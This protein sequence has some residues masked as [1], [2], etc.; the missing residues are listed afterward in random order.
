MRKGPAFAAFDVG[1]LKWAPMRP[2]PHLYIHIPKTA[3]TSLS[4]AV[5][6]HWGEENF[7][8]L[9]AI[10]KHR[11]VRSLT[12]KPVIFGHLPYGFHQWFENAQCTYATFFR[13]PVQRVLSMYRFHRLNTSD[14]NH[15]YA[16]CMTLSQWIKRLSISQN[17]MTAYISGAVPNA[18]YNKGDA[19]LHREVLEKDLYSPIDRAHFD[20]ALSNLMQNFGFIGITERY[21]DSLVLMESM[22]GVAYYPS[23]LNVTPRPS[24]NFQKIPASDHALIRSFNAWDEQLYERALE[25]FKKQVDA[26]GGEAELKRAKS[27]FR[28]RALKVRVAAI[29]KIKNQREWMRRNRGK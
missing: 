29:D 10:P 22:L 23:R 25:L 2:T 24:R 19:V 27:S 7:T 4:K 14:P 13:D 3:G 21:E 9:W 6:R 16:A 18:W 12:S 20:R 11:N 5:K 15:H 8:H 28:K 1:G 26:F 17:L